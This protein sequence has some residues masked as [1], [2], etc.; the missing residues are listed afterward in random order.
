VSKFSLERF[1]KEWMPLFRFGNATEQKPRAPERHDVARKIGH[2]AT[3]PQASRDEVMG[4][5][6]IA[7]VT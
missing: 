1:Q 7:P 2:F 5:G 3:A 4:D 6:G